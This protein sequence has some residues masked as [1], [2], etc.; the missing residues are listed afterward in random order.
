MRYE[1]LC[2]EDTEKI[3][4]RI[5]SQAK[6]GSIYTLD[7]DLGAG[8]TV[9]AKGIA[10]G[11]GIRE[12]ISSPTFT[13]V[14]EYEGDVMPLYHFDVY[15]ISDPEEMYEIGLDDYLY[16]NGICLIEWGELIRDLL[17]AET[18]SIHI[19]KDL[20]KGTDYRMITIDEEKRE[21]IPEDSYGVSKPTGSPH[22]R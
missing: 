15:R 13:I 18:V 7:G 22:Q 5:G 4:F 11:L 2:A 10:L 6:A 20:E 14:N 8:K 17:P 1:S 19:E 9:L 12:M 16:G 3:G 21:R